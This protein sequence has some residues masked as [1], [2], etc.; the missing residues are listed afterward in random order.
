[1]TDGVWK[2]VGWGPI[3]VE[4]A[5][6]QGQALIDVLQQRARLPG[7][8]EFQDDFTLIV[9]HSDAHGVNP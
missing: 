4:A 1:M 8:G 9:I 2:Y 3:A 5:R 6:H 7:S